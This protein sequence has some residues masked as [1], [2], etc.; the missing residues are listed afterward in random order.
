MWA[1]RTSITAGQ[2][3][4]IRWT[5]ANANSVFLSNFGAG[6]LN[7]SMTVTPST[8]TS[9]SI[10][11]KG[12]SSRIKSSQVSITVNG[13]PPPPPVIPPPTAPGIYAGDWVIVKNAGTVGI[14]VR[15]D[16]NTS[17]A[18]RG[19]LHNGDVVY[20][21]ETRVGSDGYL[22]VRHDQAGGGWSHCHGTWQGVYYEYMEKYN[23]PPDH[24][25]PDIHAGDWARVKDVN[26]VGLAVRP[27][28]FTNI[29]AVGY[30]WDGDLA[31]IQETR[32]GS[33]GYLWARHDQA[34]GGWSHAHGTWAGVYYVYMEKYFPARIWWTALPEVGRWY[35]SNERLGYDYDGTDAGSSE[36]PPVGNG[37]EMY[38]AEAGIGWHDY[39]ASS[40]N[41]VASPSISWTGGWDDQAPSVSLA[42][43]SAPSGTW[44]NTTQFAKWNS[45]DA[46]SGVK[47]N[48]YSWPKSSS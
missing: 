38:L 37:R 1:D 27:D 3:T 48:R 16:T 45:S 23:K 42:N 34:G 17:I 24:P 43:D 35:R 21:Q 5:S 15:S 14:A 9:Y 13:V 22:W 26:P 41:R 40:S 33:D 25:A 10:T 18:A 4:V 8:S 47:V 46:H 19:Y 20:V 44:L 12:A 31:Y 2:S 11:V 29:K 7:G 32:D 6:A 30:L 39:S 36:S 28:T